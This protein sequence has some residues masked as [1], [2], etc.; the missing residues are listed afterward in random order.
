MSLA[1][2]E[3]DYAPTAM[4]GLSLRR[5]RDLA[6]GENVFE[7]K[8]GDAFLMS[9]KFS[10]SEI[11]LAEL[12]LAACAGDA[13]RVVVGGLGL[14]YTARR[15]LDE[16]RVAE[17]LVV[18][19]M[20]PVIRWHEAGLVPLGRALS[21]DNRCR[22]VEGDFFALAASAAGFDVEAAGCRFDAILVDIDHTPDFHLDPTHAGFYTSAGLQQLAA[23]LRPGGVFGLWS[24]EPPDDAFT[25]RLAGV[26]ATAEAAPVTFWNPLQGCEVIQTVYLATT[27]GG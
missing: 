16:A 7:V 15:V 27:A 18:E 19:T 13:L 26:F 8:L 4:G 25:D 6:T 17:L 10:T 20:A 12:C 3:L 2:E 22:F 11:A 21:A 14:G 5:R 24:N 23:H 9:S 1:F